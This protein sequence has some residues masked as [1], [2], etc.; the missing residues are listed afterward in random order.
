MGDTNEE[1]VENEDHEKIIYYRNTQLPAWR[2]LSER[3]GIVTV[4]KR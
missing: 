2:F 3:G 1:N 4:I